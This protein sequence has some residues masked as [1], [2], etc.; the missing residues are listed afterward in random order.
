MTTPR[1]PRPEPGGPKPRPT[2]QRPRG[3]AT[4]RT[5]RLLA[6]AALVLA[7]AGVGVAAF[8]AFAPSDDA[9]Q[10]SA[11]DTAPKD[12]DLPAD[13]TVASSQYDVARKSMSLVGPSPADETTSQ[14]VVY[15]TVTCYESG[16]SD[17]LARSSDASTAAGQVVTERND[18][19]DQGFSAADASGASFLQFRHDR[20]VVYLAGQDPATGADVDAIASAFDKAMGGDGG[21]VSLATPIAGSPEPSDDTGTASES[22]GSSDDAS[23]EAPVAP[24]LEAALPTKVGDMALT[25]DS[26][27]GS[28]IL[29][30]DQGSRAITAA[31]RAAGKVPDDLKVAQA[32]DETGAS[33]LSIMAMG[34]DGLSPAKVLPLV[35]DSWLAASG[36]GVTREQVTMA[37]K[38]FTRVDRGDQLAMDYVTT[39]GDAVIVITTAD[40]AEAE[41]VAAALP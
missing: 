23:A 12:A 26:A 13:W 40:P 10:R 38:E 32:Y 28:M 33:E 6:V 16:A 9:C 1:T 18:L 29:G 31:L 19:G 39:R 5:T 15:A 36:A 3:E 30:E 34:V 20:I 8:A 25:V 21:A 27:S 17:A 22:P 4:G 41:A 7:V 2:D 37:G 14:A 24:E 35:L 11:W